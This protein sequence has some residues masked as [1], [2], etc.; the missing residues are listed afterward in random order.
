MVEFIIYEEDNIPHIIDIDGRKI[1]RDNDWGREISFALYKYGGFTL[2]LNP[3]CYVYQPPKK[4]ILY[5][6]ML[7]IKG[8]LK[9][10]Q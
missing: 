7:E 6:K 10:R 1:I 9:L 2:S 3:K 4:I 8:I 5:L